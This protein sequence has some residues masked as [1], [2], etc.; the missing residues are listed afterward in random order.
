MQRFWNFF[1]HQSRFS[2]LLLFALIVAGLFSFVTLPKESTPEIDVPIVLVT[3]VSPGASALD[4]EKLVT[5]KVE[6]HLESALTD[7]KTL[8]SSSQ[9]NVSVVTVEFDPSVDIDEKVQKVKDE[10]SKIVNELPSDANDPQVTKVDFSDFPTIFFSITSRFE[11]NLR[12]IVLDVEDEVESIQGVSKVTIEGIENQEV[13]VIVDPERLSQYSLS[14]ADV[15]GSLGVSNARVPVGSI[16]Y[17]GVEYDLQYDGGVESIE[18]IATLPVGTFAGAPVYVQDVAEVVADG[19]PSRTLSRISDEGSSFQSAVTFTVYKQKGAD[20]A[21][22]SKRVADKIEEID[23]GLNENLSLVVWYDAGEEMRKEL[24]D[25][26]STGAQTVLL[27][28]LI[29]WIFIGIREA[30]IAG[31]SL[32]L[33]FLLAFLL[34]DITGNTLNFVSLFSLILAIGILVD[35]AIVVTESIHTFIEEG[36]SPTESALRTIREFSKPLTAGTFTTIAVFIPLF[37]L[38][39]ITGEFIASIPFTVVSVLAASLF[40]SLALIPLVASFVLR[41]EVKDRFLHFRKKMLSD[42]DDLYRST[43]TTFL[44]DRALKKK[45]FRILIIGFFVLLLSPA[46]GILP[47]SFFP[48]DDIAQLYIDIELPVGTT[49]EETDNEMR[50][51]EERIREQEGVEIAIATAG[52]SNAF[53]GGGSGTHLGTFTLIL[54]E[55]RDISS[56]EVADVLRQDL[57][58]LSRMSDVRVAQPEGGPPVGAPVV[59]KIFGD[60][61]QDIDIARLRVQSL[62]EDI[63]GVE[64]VTSSGDNRPNEF[65]LEIDRE[66]LSFYGVSPFQ[67]GRELGMFL[68]GDEVFTF[69]LEDEDVSVRLI[70]DISSE[71]G[72]TNTISP[73]AVGSI[74]ITTP[75]GDTPL[76]SLATLSFREGRSVIRHEEGRRFETV[77]SDV[78]G[79][80]PP[81]VIAELQDAL[82]REGIPGSIDISFGGETEESARAFKEMLLALAAGLLL[83]VAVLVLQF[84]SYRKTLFIMVTVPLSLIGVFLGLIL[85]RQSLS[86]PSMLGFIALSGIVVNNAIILIDVID[87]TKGDKLQ[88]V[89]VGATSRLRPIALT[90]L[91]TVAGM[92]PLLFVSAL[93]TPLAA[94]IIFGL[95]FASVITLFVVPAL[96]LKWG[97]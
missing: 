85:T 8:S 83:I 24:G 5:N 22:V 2:F 28:T 13:R 54:S 35:A 50:L 63:E 55:D 90:T 4:V 81:Q 58:Q 30:L 86:F 65:V 97:K 26:A 31:V 67:V 68:V 39:G 62:L 64:N 87:S 96:Y 69:R 34:L 6:S 72:E 15:R 9:S 17:E 75:R 16:Q 51:F 14:I 95:I 3:T 37:F 73:G 74:L 79:V 44:G 12:D 53:G 38:S 43:L 71:E 11:G 20:L 78:S 66:A 42:I 19:R 82:E 25:L 49:L 18:T 45:S 93:W 36:L 1:V 76:S 91:T 29:L 89:I 33:S 21:E 47:V 88:R 92:I 23:S 56:F 57:A 94:A 52:A 80:M 32:P 41:K 46:F 84:N 61:F 59:V 40:V 27:V 60:D 48:Q 70:Q 10:I 77:S 7:V